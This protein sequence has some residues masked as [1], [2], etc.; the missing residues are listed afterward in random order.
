MPG[1]LRLMVYLK[2]FANLWTICAVVVILI[3]HFMIVYEWSPVTGLMPY[4]VKNTSNVILLLAPGAIAAAIQMFLEKRIKSG[5]TQKE[6][7]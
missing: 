4:N 2:W 3:S 7:Q 6:N 1:S 5:R